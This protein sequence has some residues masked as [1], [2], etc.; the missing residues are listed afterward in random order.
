MGDCKTSD[1]EADTSV[2]EYETN[3]SAGNHCCYALADK[4]REFLHSGTYILA[5]KNIKNSEEVA[6]RM[7]VFYSKFF[8]SYNVVP[9][10]KINGRYKEAG[11]EAATNA[12]YLNGKYF[13][14]FG[15]IPIELVPASYIPFNYKNYEMNLDRLSKGDIFTENDYQRVLLDYKKLPDPSNKS[16]ITDKD[17]KGYL[18]YCLKDQLNNPKA[19]FNAYCINNMASLVI[20]LWVLIIGTLFNILF[21]YYRDIYS[22][23]L[24]FVA[25][26]LILVAVIWK[27]I[28]ILNVD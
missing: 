20:V 17:L 7:K 5:Y 22:Y 1:C 15:I 18:E 16:Y 27:M 9:T 21:Y 8:Q 24:L 10:E 11:K 13:D 28:Y 4:T 26:L 12:K 25:I 19:I 3:T 6:D 23:I 14:I 2:S